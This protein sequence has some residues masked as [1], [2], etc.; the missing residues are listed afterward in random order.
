VWTM[1]KAAKGDHVIYILLKVGLTL[2]TAVIL[3]VV[4]F[5]LFIIPAIIAVAIGVGIYAAVPGL[6]KTPSGI[7]LVVTVAAMGIFLLLLVGA[8][9]AAPVVVFFQA[10]VLTFFSSRYEP[11]WKW[12]HPP[13][14][15]PLPPP[16]IP[17]P[18]PLPAM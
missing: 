17:E 8:V 16:I 9:V 18:P 3:A 12:M 2:L 15:A 10:Y 1:V 6:L 13:D 4:Q 14:P 11:L 5:I 7:A